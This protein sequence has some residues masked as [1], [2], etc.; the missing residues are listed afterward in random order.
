MAATSG[1]GAVTQLAFLAL[2]ALNLVAGFHAL[3][4]LMSVG[5]MML[6]AAA[7]RMWTHR[8]DATIA[9][10]AALGVIA[11]YA[12]LVASYALG[13][14]SGPS[15]VLAAGLLY[16]ISLVFGPAGGMLRNAPKRRHLEG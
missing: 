8:L 13:L 15:I 7:A 5:L 1:A 9:L 16:A 10:A 12:G 4:T 2:L 14:P 3:G 11:A 6:P